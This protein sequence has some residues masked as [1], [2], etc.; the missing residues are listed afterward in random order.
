MSRWKNAIHSFR[1]GWASMKED[2]AS[3]ISVLRKGDIVP[4][5]WMG[6][7]YWLGISVPSSDAAI[8]WLPFWVGLCS[9]LLF[10]VAWLFTSGLRQIVYEE[11]GEHLR[12]QHDVIEI[13]KALVTAL[14]RRSAVLAKQ[15]LAS[16]DLRV[17]TEKLL[18]V[19][20]AHIR[21]QGSLLRE[22]QQRLGQSI[23]A[24]DDMDDRVQSMLDSTEDHMQAWEQ[25]QDALDT[26]S[27]GIPARRERLVKIVEEH[28][29]GEDAHES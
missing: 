23:V 18:R 26:T 8:E 24:E 2:G 9:Y 22:I 17:V 14:E 20:A 21:E 6:A 15:N 10:G 4:V 19:Q 25:V 3:F 28:D 27:P 12:L 1:T 16:L 29:H 7:F 5:V 13:D 11:R